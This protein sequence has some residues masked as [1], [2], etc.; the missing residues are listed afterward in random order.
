MPRAGKLAD[1]RLDLRPNGPW[2]EL[3]SSKHLKRTIVNWT[4]RQMATRS[5]LLTYPPR[6]EGDPHE[7]Y[8]RAVG[9]LVAAYRPGVRFSDRLRHSVAAMA[10]YPDMHPDHDLY[11]FGRW[12]LLDEH[13][14]FNPPR[15][16]RPDSLDIFRTVAVVLALQHYREKL[17]KSTQPA[18]GKKF[19]PVPVK[20]TRTD[21][22]EFWPVLFVE[23]RETGRFANGLRSAERYLDAY[24]SH[25]AAQRHDGRRFIARKGELPG[26][27]AELKKIR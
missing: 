25:L 10:A 13:P 26:V 22:S 11:F 19:K 24:L 12:L 23:K 21:L 1:A 18:S 8:I 5:D 3:D 20:I 6:S 4:A 14:G 16:R 2:S 17:R 15:G 27:L 7:G 9:G